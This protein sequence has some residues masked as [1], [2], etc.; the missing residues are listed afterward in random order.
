MIHPLLLLSPIAC[1]VH[2]PYATGTYS[3]ESSLHDESECT[4]CPGGWYCET[5]A[6]TEPTGECGEGYYCVEGS[7]EKEPA[8][9][10]CNIG[11]YCPT[12][13]SQPIPC[14]NNSYVSEGAKREGE[15]ERDRQT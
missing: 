6:L 4:I 9:D 13:V 12:G 7:T 10:F 5:A 2:S 11:A 15:R 1:H 14:R 8:G 3:N